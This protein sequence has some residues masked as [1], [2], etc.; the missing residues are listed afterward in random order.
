MRFDPLAALVKLGNFLGPL[1]HKWDCQAAHGRPCA[2]WKG[3]AEILIHDLIANTGKEEPPPMRPAI[4]LA[5]PPPPREVEMTPKEIVQTA[6]LIEMR[7]HLDSVRT[8]LDRQEDTL[9][10][11]PGAV[12]AALDNFTAALA[13][14]LGTTPSVPVPTP[15]AQASPW[16]KPTAAQTISFATRIGWAVS[17][18]DGD[19]Q[20]NASPQTPQIVACDGTA[21]DAMTYASFGFMPDG[22]RIV[23]WAAMREAFRKR[24]DKLNDAGTVEQANGLLQGAGNLDAPFVIFLSMLGQTTASLFGEV[25]FVVSGGFGDIQSW[26]TNYMAPTPKGPNAP[27]PS[28]G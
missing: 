6:L 3:E 26:V 19:R 18:L 10:A 7:D 16:W 1:P 17:D 27:G 11:L 5:L 12:Q 22:Y 4:R 13:T 24:C 20:A 25:P 21:S 2:C 9:M 28:G 15:P 14:A 23:P 8:R